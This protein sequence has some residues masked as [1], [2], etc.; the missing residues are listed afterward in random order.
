[1]LKGRDDTLYIGEEGSLYPKCLLE[2]FE[3]LRRWQVVLVTTLSLNNSK[4][5]ILLQYC[6]YK[7][8]LTKIKVSITLQSISQ[9]RT[10][11]TLLSIVRF[12]RNR[13]R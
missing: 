8:N 5:I 10:M 11:E 12:Y 7:I 1:M 9:L 13:P 2:I 3:L 4:C 6:G